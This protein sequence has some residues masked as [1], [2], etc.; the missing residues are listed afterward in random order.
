[1][2]EYSLEFINPRRS[3]FS[4]EQIVPLIPQTI[5]SVSVLTSSTSQ[6]TV[7]FIRNARVVVV[8]LSTAGMRAEVGAKAYN[9]FAQ[10]KS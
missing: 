2:R 9:K 6:H 1:M 4:G 7:S 5:F 3:R 10:I 8:G